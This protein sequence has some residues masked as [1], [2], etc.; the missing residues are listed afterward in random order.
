MKQKIIIKKDLEGVFGVCYRIHL[1]LNLEASAR[2]WPNISFYPPCITISP[3]F[4]TK[5]RLLFSV[6]TCGIMIPF[7]KMIDLD[8]KDLNVFLI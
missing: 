3:V 7:A 4:M 1:N 5:C 8:W 2:Q 6:Y